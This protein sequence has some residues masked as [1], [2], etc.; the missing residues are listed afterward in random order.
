MATCYPGPKPSVA[1]VTAPENTYRS[2]LAARVVGFTNACGA[3]AWD[4]AMAHHFG[5]GH[6]RI[7]GKPWVPDVS[8]QL[9]LRYTFWNYLKLEISCM[10]EYLA[11]AYYWLNDWV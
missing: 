4:H 3:P 5:Y 6:Q 11:I 9:G 8:G 7:G 1:I 10:R 2:V